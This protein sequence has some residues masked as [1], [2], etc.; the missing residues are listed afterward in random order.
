MNV[1]NVLNLALS[2]G[3]EYVLGAEALQSPACYFVYG[4]LDA[5]EKGRLISPGKGH[6]EIVCIVSGDVFLR[7]EKESFAL[8]AGEAFYLRGEESYLMENNCEARA[9]YVISGGHSEQHKH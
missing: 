1:Y 6:E 2:C 4:F 9:V 3:G 5:D 7:G 8:T